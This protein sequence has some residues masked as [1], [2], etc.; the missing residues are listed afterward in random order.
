MFAVRGEFHVPRLH[1]SCIRTCGS[2]SEISMGR[3]SRNCPLM[4]ASPNLARLLVLRINAID[5]PLVLPRT[6]IELLLPVLGNPLGVLNDVPVHVGDPQRSVGA[7][8]D[9]R[10]AEPVVGRRQKLRLLLIVGA[11]AG[12]R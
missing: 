3:Y 5:P 1:A 12:E 7:S 4:V 10:R 2:A 8:R 11:L 9:C 6:Q